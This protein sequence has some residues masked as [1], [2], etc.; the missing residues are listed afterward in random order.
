MWETFFWRNKRAATNSNQYDRTMII[1]A[2]FEVENWHVKKI[3]SMYSHLPLSV[4]SLSKVSVIHG[5]QPGWEADDPP[6]DKSSNG[7]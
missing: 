7:Q 4:V 6:S 5:G 1:L 3:T 2:V